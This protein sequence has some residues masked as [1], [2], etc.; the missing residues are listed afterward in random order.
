MHVHVQKVNCAGRKD[1]YFEVP[2]NQL[3]H[4]SNPCHKH[5]SRTRRQEVEA[6]QAGA[7]AERAA[8]ADAEAALSEARASLRHTTE[9]LQESLA[10]GPRAA[11]AALLEEKEAA[12]GAAAKAVEE[13][14]AGTRELN[15]KKN[16]GKE[17]SLLAN[18]RDEVS[19][20]DSFVFF[21]FGQP[22]ANNKG[23]VFG[24]V[25][26][27]LVFACSATELHDIT[28]VWICLFTA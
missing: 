19:R 26:M 21:M 28:T 1:I 8:R 10:N 13:A 12:E 22:G 25:Q 27:L 15:K 6:A 2:I 3:Q 4:E 18:Q 24:V 11:L 7:A 9:R 16:R 17:L 23:E 5:D 14:A 20:Q